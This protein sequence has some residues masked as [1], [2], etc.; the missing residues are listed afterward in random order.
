RND[1]A[2]RYEQLR[3]TASYGRQVARGP[4]KSLAL[5][6]EQLP[7]ARRDVRGRRGTFDSSWTGSARGGTARV[8][9]WSR[10]DQPRLAHDSSVRRC[11]PAVYLPRLT[12]GI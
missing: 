7:P 9:R 1:A 2:I 12:H 4:G 10:R 5:Q 3:W 8:A 6:Y 11:Q